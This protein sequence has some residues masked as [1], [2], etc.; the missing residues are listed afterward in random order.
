MLVGASLAGIP[1]VLYAAGA[2]VAACGTFVKAWQSG[3]S[4]KRVE[5]SVNGQATE[6]LARNRYL[7]SVLA[8]HGIDPDE[9]PT[10]PAA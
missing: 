10:D 6:L 5:K 2:F 3:R 8:K 4:Q 7:R 1:G 9:S